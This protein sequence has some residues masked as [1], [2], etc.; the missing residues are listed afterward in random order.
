MYKKS[1]KTSTH[2]KQKFEKKAQSHTKGSRR[3]T[4]SLIT[5]TM[6]SMK[7]MT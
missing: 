6:G 1:L 4:P 5:Q 2:F 3:Q 7:T